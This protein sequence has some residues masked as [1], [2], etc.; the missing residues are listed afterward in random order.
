M[1]TYHQAASWGAIAEVVGKDELLEMAFQV[2]ET[3]QTKARI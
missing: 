1:G 3:V 2:E